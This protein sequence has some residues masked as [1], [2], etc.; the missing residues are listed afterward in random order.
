MVAFTTK[1][2]ARNDE[3]FF[4]ALLVA[5]I[6]LLVRRSHGKTKQEKHTFKKTSTEL[7]SDV[8][9]KEVT[10]LRGGLSVQCSMECASLDNCQSFIFSEQ[11]CILVGDASLPGEEDD[12]ATAQMQ[13]LE[14]YKRQPVSALTT[15]TTEETTQTATTKTEETTSSK[16]FPR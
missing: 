4:R 12:A 3:M 5:T 16:N 2:E 13:A 1:V 9:L 8:T 14:R 6:Y 7:G 11:R 15:T 10:S